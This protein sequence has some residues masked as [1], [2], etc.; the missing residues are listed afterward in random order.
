[1]V[2]Q[3]NDLSQW[4]IFN[5]EPWLSF[6]NEHW[7]ESVLWGPEMLR[8]LCSLLPPISTLMSLI[9]RAQGPQTFH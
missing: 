7:N 6:G 3:H 5:L 2:N 1:M 8:A 9:M 4:R